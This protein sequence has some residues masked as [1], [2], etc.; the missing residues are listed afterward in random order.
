MAQRL[1]NFPHNSGN[2]TS[3]M[4]RRSDIYFGQDASGRFLP[5]LTAF[6]VYLAAIFIA[7]LFVLNGLTQQFST[8]VANTMTIQIPVT[9]SPSWDSAR[10]NEVLQKL[11]RTNGVM[12]ST[13]IPSK[14]VA[15]LLRPWLGAATE[16]DQLPLPQVVDVIVD[17]KTESMQMISAA[18]SR[19]LARRSCSMITGS[20]CLISLMLCDQRKLWRC[21]LWF[22]PGLHWSVRSY[23]RPGQ[24]SGSKRHYYRVAF[25]RR[26]R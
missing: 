12:S 1:E 17:R 21:L 25:Y 10:R 16:S 11:Q 5:W 7:G 18:C 6:M 14:K 4:L 22:S 13:H 19:I 9:G 3:E 2:P 8:E 23:F 20:G 15:E 24:A 26:Q